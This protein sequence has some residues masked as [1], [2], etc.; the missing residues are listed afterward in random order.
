MNRINILNKIREDLKDDIIDFYD[1]SAHRVY[2]EVKPESITKVAKYLWKDLQ[3][4]FNIA[5][6]VDV[7]YHMEILYH[8]TIESIKTTISIRVKLDKK[9]LE[10]DSITPIMKGA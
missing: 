3:A 8:F 1:K 4:R 6:G 2:I 7:R 10:I 9:N 5:S